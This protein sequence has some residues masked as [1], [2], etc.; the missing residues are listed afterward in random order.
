MKIWFN[1]YKGEENITQQNKQTQKHKK[2]KNID[3]QKTFNEQISNS[4]Q[5]IYNYNNDI[6]LNNNNINHSFSQ[7]MPQNNNQNSQ[8]CEDDYKNFQKNSNYNNLKHSFS[9]IESCIITQ[10]NSQIDLEEDEEE[11][12][13]KEDNENNKK[14]EIKENQDKKKCSLSEHNEVDAIIF[15]QECKVYMCKKCE[16]I[17]S[18]LLKNHHSYSLDENINEIFT[19][20]CT[21]PNHSMSLE[22]FCKTHNQLCCAAC[23]SKIRNKGNGKHKNCK[24]FDISKIK[25]KKKNTLKKNISNLEKISDKLEPSIQELKT[26]FEKISDAKNNLKAKV[27]KIFSRIRNELNERE[28]NLFLEIDQKFQEIFFNEEFIKESEKLTGLVKISLEKGKI[29]EDEWKDER[30]LNKLIN[31][32]INLENTI[33]NINEVYD[34]INNYNSKKELEIEFIPKDEEIEERL[35]EIDIKH[36]GGVQVK[37]NNQNNLQSDECGIKINNVNNIINQNDSNEPKLFI[38]VRQNKNYY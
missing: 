11:E 2:R 15:C 1:G 26:I 20:L 38:P 27:Q 34:K 8:E 36:F 30:K 19:G 14:D 35:K 37:N 3:N 5:N 9:Q 33:K 13:E 23:I 32:C 22:Y 29:K 24:V 31:D 17:H 18:G 12:D 16:K 25:N 4:Y 28:D 6:N 10:G 21:K 7:L